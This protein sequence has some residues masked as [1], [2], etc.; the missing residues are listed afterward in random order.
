MQR[1]GNPCVLLIGMKI[2]TATK[3]NSMEVPQRKVACDLAI[4]LLGIYPKET[5]T[6]T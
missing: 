2:G 6:L 4:K 1:K 5:N 3:E